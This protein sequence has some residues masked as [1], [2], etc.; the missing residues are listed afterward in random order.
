M[1]KNT[2]ITRYIF[3]LIILFALPFLS[4]AIPVSFN[5]L[6]YGAKGDGS[7]LN[8]KPIQSAIDACA[9]GGGGTV[10]FPAGKFL[11][12]TLFLKSYVTLHLDAGAVLVGSKNLNDYP[13]TVSNIRSYTDNYTDK[14]LVFGEGLEHIARFRVRK[15]VEFP[16]GDKA[17][18]IVSRK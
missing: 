3:I 14:S 13:V 5:I 16:G 17:F 10:Y 1:F 9:K 11:S 15:I 8:T 7:T 2:S 6:D 4:F 18:Y 12:G